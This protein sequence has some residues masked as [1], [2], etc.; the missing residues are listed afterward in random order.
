MKTN[1][2]Y[3]NEALDALRGNWAPAV[4]MTLIY[5]AI[6]GICSGCQS[7]IS[8]TAAAVA[9]GLVGATFLVSIFILGP[10]SIGYANSLRYLYEKGDTELIR[11]L[12]SL[13]LENY[14]HTVW[15][16]LLM[17][18]K[19]FLWTLLLIIPGIVKALAYSMTPFILKDHPELTAS[20]AIRKSEE[21]MNGHKFDLFYLILSF[22][23]WIILACLTAGI[24]FLWL[25]PYMETSVA[26]F[27]N[28]LKGQ[29]VLEAEVVS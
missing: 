23:G 22:L 2:D 14:L 3:K 10:L 8:P 25:E 17:V 27:Y 11:N 15:T 28:D 29:Q 12:F 5:L 4:L 6:L 9:W 19:I 18:I 16:F 1:Q 26:A 24:G 21:M 20:Q 13:S 7:F